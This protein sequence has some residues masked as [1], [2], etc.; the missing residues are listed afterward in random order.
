[1]KNFEDQAIELLEDNKKVPNLIAKE[2][3]TLRLGTSFREDRTCLSSFSLL[4]NFTK[5][6]ELYVYGSPATDFENL[7][8]YKSL[9]V[10][11]LG[12]TSISDLS[13][14]TALSNLDTLCLYETAV[15]NIRPLETNRK[16]KRLLLIDL[17]IE[18]FEPLSKLVS[19]KCLNLF[20]TK[21][22]SISARKSAGESLSG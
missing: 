20:G 17:V 12:G 13:K 22:A 4:S 21:R 19:L 7:T 3:K 5:L 8:H 15:T 18:N 9:K 6:E 16:L 10:L 2:V 1:M 11:D 14:I